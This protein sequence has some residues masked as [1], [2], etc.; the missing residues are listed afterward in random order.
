MTSAALS[1]APPSND[2]R[3][4]RDSP[5]TLVVSLRLRLDDPDDPGAARVVELLQQLTGGLAPVIET[6][7]EPQS[8]DPPALRI[9]PDSRTVYRGSA[10]IQLTRRE[11]DLLLCLADHPQQVL[12][13]AQLISQAWGHPYTGHRSVDVHI[14]RLRVKVGLPIIRTVHGVGYRLDDDVSVL[15]Q[16]LAPHRGATGRREGRGGAPAMR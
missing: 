2:P 13:R 14:R 4:A 7:V 16:R 9:L 10:E 15:V 6:T 1:L 3:S 12:S 8:T 5:A 11:F